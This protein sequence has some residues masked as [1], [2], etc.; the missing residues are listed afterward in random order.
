MKILILIALA[1]WLTVVFI[2]TYIQQSRK[3]HYCPRCGHEWKQ[4]SNIADDTFVCKKCGMATYSTR[5]YN[6]EFKDRSENY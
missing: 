6:A 5:R 3:K 4:S 1:G 2:L